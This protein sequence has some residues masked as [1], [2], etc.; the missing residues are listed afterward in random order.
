MGGGLPPAT[1]DNPQWPVR[2]AVDWATRQLRAACVE[3]PAVDARLLA[4]HV[5]DIAPGAL[6]ASNGFTPMQRE[7][8]EALVRQRA[9]RIPL[10]Y[11]T[12]T[13]PFRYLD[14]AVG[15][16]VFIP[17]PETESLVE[18]GLN[19]LREHPTV[20]SAH[21]G[22]ERMAS[23]PVTSEI[24]VVDLCSGSGAVAASVASEAPP[25]LRSTN[26]TGSTAHTVRVFAVECDQR[27][28]PWL[29]RNAEPRGV[30]VV[31]GDAT[32]FGV[33]SQ[34]DGRVDLVLTNPPYVPAADASDLP[35]EVAGHDP[36]RAL[37]GGPDG[38]DVIRPLITRAAVLLRP[39]GALA[40]EH[41]ETQSA[42]IADLLTADGR[43]V[44]VSH[45][46]DLAGR[47]RFTTASRA[48]PSG[49][50]ADLRT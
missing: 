44:G 3:S 7:S 35:P 15:A 13:A 22:S 30:E 2:E 38:L 45:H 41:G 9:S 49:R 26:A 25:L 33:L 17:R 6:P 4:A 24:V 47:P 16:G 32:S 39:G 21:V 11:L 5:L 27:A 29:R 1:A 14:L 19:W 12:G 48:A 42:A 36:H 20:V 40:I 37:F 10:Q 31:A 50:V 28:L 18:W 43:F 8:F 34:L 46:P 23:E